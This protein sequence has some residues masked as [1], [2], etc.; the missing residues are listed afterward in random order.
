MK[1]YNLKLKKIGDADNSKFCFRE[2]SL[3]QEGKVV[4]NLIQDQLTELEVQK[5]VEFFKGIYKEQF[6]VT[7]VKK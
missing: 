1:G 4:Y 2:F 5:Y 6:E 3:T 7:L